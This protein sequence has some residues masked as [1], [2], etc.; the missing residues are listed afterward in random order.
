MRR[1]LGFFQELRMKTHHILILIF[2]L[3]AVF[4]IANW[5][6]RPRK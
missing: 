5:L 4:M 3:G 1:S 6:N 2:A